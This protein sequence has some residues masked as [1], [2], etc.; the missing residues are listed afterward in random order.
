LKSRTILPHIVVGDG[1]VIG[2]GVEEQENDVVDCEGGFVVDD[3]VA[4]GDL[5]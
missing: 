4:S 3:I 2:E 1:V 5:G